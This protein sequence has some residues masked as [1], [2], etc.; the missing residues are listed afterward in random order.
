MHVIS[1]Y[2]LHTRMC[3]DIIQTLN[4]SCFS[5]GTVIAA[6]E[7]GGGFGRFARHEGD[8]GLDRFLAC[9]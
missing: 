8:D 6:V 3:P 5:V 9:R 1:Q 2:P 4:R 7:S